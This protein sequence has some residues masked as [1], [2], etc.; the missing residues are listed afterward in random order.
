MGTDN[1]VAERAEE[2]R[3]LRDQIGGLSAMDE[4]E[5]VFRDTSPRTRKVTIYSMKDGEELRI[6]AHLLE[7]TLAKRFPPQDGGGY[8]FTAHK[9]RAPVF[10]LGTVR[11][12]L[13]PDGPER[14]LLD[15]LGIGQVCMSGHLANLH[16]KRIHAQRRHSGEWEAYQAAIADQKE[17]EYRQRQEAQTAA[18]LE[19]ARAAAG[20]R[21]AKKGKA[22]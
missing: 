15:E 12:F 19:L 21:E 14:P 11:C 7:R 1:V 2:V 8:M 17:E 6:P 9:D 3:D 10:K 5:I 20:G 22:E 16:S 18:T 13:H 4:Q